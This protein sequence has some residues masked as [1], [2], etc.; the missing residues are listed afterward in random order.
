MSNRTL[1]ELNHDFPPSRESYVRKQEWVEA[2][3]DYMTSGDRHYLPEGVTF[4]HSRHHSEPD[5]M[6]AFG[7]MLEALKKI[8]AWEFDFRGDCVAD[9]QK[10]A[11]DAIEKAEE[12]QK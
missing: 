12:K 11:R 7:D 4:K 5:P 8:A 2:M 10:V 3:T 9:A 1:V 6:A